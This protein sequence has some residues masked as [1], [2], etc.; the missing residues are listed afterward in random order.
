M[1]IGLDVSVGFIARRVIAQYLR[2]QYQTL[3]EFPIPIPYSTASTSLC[4]IRSHLPY[5]ASIGNK[6]YE[7]WGDVSEIEVW[8]I[9]H[10]LAL[11]INYGS[12]SYSTLPNDLFSRGELIALL[13]MQVHPIFAS[14]DFECGPEPTLTVIFRCLRVACKAGW[15]QTDDEPQLG[16]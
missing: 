9:P 7:T 5:M 4:H 10:H 16:E 2:V 1:D 11:S 13:D 14:E 8:R 3:M 12:L 6:S 15:I